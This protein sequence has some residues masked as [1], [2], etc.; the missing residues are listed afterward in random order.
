M[1]RYLIPFVLLTSSGC[2][3]TADRL[4][5]VPETISIQNQQLVLS[6]SV[7]TVERGGYP[8]YGICFIHA[9]DSTPLPSSLTMDI[10][11]LVHN[12]EVWKTELVDD[13]T[14]NDPERVTMAKTFRNGPKWLPG[15]VVDVIVQ[16]RF[17]NSTQ[18][19]R[20][21]NQRVNAVVKMFGAAANKRKTDAHTL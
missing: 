4:R 19:I 7:I 10:A 17:A 18:L 5:A 20:A 1:Q 6:A 16:V 13:H 14:L 11:W 3:E 2:G 21:P 12:Q 15:T 8:I 9:T